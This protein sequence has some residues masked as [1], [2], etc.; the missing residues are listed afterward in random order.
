MGGVVD[1]NDSVRSLKEHQQK[2]EAS[3]KRHHPAKINTIG[4]NLPIIFFLNQIRNA[5]IYP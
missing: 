2:A 4:D 1:C 3:A 5:W